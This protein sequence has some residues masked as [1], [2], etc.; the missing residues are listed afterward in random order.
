MFC[1]VLND[2]LSFIF[3]LQGLLSSGDQKLCLTS[4]QIQINE[5]LPLKFCVCVGGLLNRIW[6]WIQRKDKG[7]LVTGQQALDLVLVSTTAWGVQKNL[8]TPTENRVLIKNKVGVGDSDS[9]WM[10]VP[11]TASG[12]A[13]ASLGI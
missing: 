4:H 9:T 1:S 2:G 6:V 3:L 8:V 10:E 12:C 5:L 13:N 7:T 11:A